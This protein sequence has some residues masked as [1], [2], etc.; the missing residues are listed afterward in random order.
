MIARHWN[1][2]AAGLALAFAQPA[3]AATLLVDG[4]GHLT[5]ATG[6][7][8]DGVSYDVQFL[9]GT[10]VGLFGGCTTAQFAFQGIAAA[11]DASGALASQVL[12]T[13]SNT[14]GLVQGCIGALACAALIPFDG[15][16]T[17]VSFTYDQLRAGVI[18]MGDDSQS[19]SF[20]STDSASQVYSVF[21][22]SSGAVPEPSTWFTMIVGLAVIGLAMRKR[23]RNLPDPRSRPSAG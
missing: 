12:D 15:D 10:C 13:Y 11:T 23:S 14:P 21:S 16:G 1:A 3:D 9:D 20:D 5:G 6:V 4:S 8:V 17:N 22:R 18:N 7:L 2:L 19:A